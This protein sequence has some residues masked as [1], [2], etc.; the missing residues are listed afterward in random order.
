MPSRPETGQMHPRNAQPLMNLAW[1]PQLTWADPTLTTLEDQIHIPIRSERP[2]ELGVNDGNAARVLGGLTADPGYAPMFAAAFPDEPNPG[3]DHVVQ[4]LASFLRTMTS[5]DSPV[6]RYAQGDGA[7]LT[8][9]A[10]RGLALFGDDR[11]ECHQCHSG[12]TMTV[13]YV[14]AE[15]PPGAE[16]GMFFTNALYDLDGTGAYPEGNQGLYE[17]TGDPRHRGLFRPPSLRNIALTAPY[18]HDGSLETLEE[19][20]DHYASGGRPRDGADPGKVMRGHEHRH[21]GPIRGFAMTE[22][23]KADMIAFLTA[24]TDD[25]FVTRSDLADPRGIADTAD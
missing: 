1:L 22:E 13:S 21:G 2:V 20:L 5:F 6:D 14:D 3:W 25:G 8:P 11:F 7:A 12:P 15:T 17:V 23:E 19:V 4:S 10:R 16:P 18:M 9:P 24:L